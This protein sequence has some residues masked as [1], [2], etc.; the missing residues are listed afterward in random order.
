MDPLPALIDATKL[1]AYVI[2]YSS[3]LGKSLLVSYNDKETRRNWYMDVSHLL[4]PEQLIMGE[5][6]LKLTVTLSKL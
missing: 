4:T 5:I 6:P 1:T 2:V 3:S